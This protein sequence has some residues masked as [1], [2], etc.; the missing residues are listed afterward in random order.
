MYQINFTTVLPI[1]ADLP[2]AIFR[3]LA[4]SAISVVLSMIVG[5]VGALCR[6]SDNGVVSTLA[7][8]YVEFGRNIPLL[9]IM[10]LI[11]FGL[12]EMGIRIGGFWAATIALTL[13]S[14]AYMTEIF[15]AGLLAIPRGQFEAAIAQGMTR[16]QSFRHLVF[17]QVLQVIY[18]PLGNQVIATVLGSAF[19]SAIGVNDVAAWM[20]NAGSV[21]YHYFEVFL[22]AAAVYIVI[23]QLS[24]LSGC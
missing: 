3:T 17:P 20:E 7:G 18:A 24:T 9:V 19:A 12:P 23:C 1:L 4:I 14:G 22:I 11:F 13:A 16:I 8:A 2:W 15:R 5:T 21:S 6:R 10:F